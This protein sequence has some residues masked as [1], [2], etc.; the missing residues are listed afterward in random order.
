MFSRT[1][2]PVAH[3]YGEIRYGSVTLVIQDGHVVQIDKSEKVNLCK[4][5]VN[6]WGLVC[7][8]ASLL[9]RPGVAVLL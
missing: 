6:L 8:S 1:R 5:L 2:N 9:Y 4:S 3:S 7:F